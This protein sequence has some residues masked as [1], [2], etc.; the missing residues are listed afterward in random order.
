MTT[1]RLY[2]VID[3][4]GGIVGEA[5]FDAVS[6]DDAIREVQSTHGALPD[7]WRIVPATEDM[8]R[9]YEVMTCD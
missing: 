7:G 2:A 8:L 3:A 1:R 9:E 4:G 5:P 6:D